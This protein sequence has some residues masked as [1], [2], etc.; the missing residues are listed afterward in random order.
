MESAGVHQSSRQFTGSLCVQEN[1]FLYLLWASTPALSLRASRYWP[2]ATP[3]KRRLR[4]ALARARESQRSGRAWRPLGGDRAARIR[5]RTARSWDVVV[6]DWQE[7]SPDLSSASPVRVALTPASASSARRLAARSQALAVPEC[8]HGASRRRLRSGASGS[9][10]RNAGPLSAGPPADHRLGRNSPGGSA[11][12]ASRRGGDRGGGC[13][14][15]PGRP[16]TQ[17]SR[18]ATVAIPAQEAR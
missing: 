6:P 14:Q 16:W 12:R 17:A 5:V 18:A 9:L 3:R 11:G 2:T 8:R 4:C 13:P 7:H 10:R 1:P 15:V